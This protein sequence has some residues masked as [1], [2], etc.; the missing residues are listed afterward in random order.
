MTAGGHRAKSIIKL[1]TTDQVSTKNMEKDEIFTE[2]VLWIHW[3]TLEFRSM[4][5]N[6]LYSDADL[7]VR[8]FHWDPAS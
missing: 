8:Y 6:N 2:T 3:P 5:Q 4:D 1:L 7:R